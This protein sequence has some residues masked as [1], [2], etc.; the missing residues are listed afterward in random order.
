[1]KKTFALI[2]ALVMVLALAACGGKTEAPAATNAPAQNAPAATTAASSDEKT[3]SDRPYYVRDASEVTGTVTVYT[4]I[5]ET[6]Q[7]ALKSLWSKYYPDCK[8]EIIIWSLTASMLSACLT[9]PVLLL[10]LRTEHLLNAS[11]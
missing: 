5:G 7:E 9:N 6:E 4:T 11:T 8:I 1:M 10:K 2:L 3:E